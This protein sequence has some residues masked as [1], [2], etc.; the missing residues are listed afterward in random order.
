VRFIRLRDEIVADF[1][2]PGE[3]RHDS[4]S[5][6]DGHDGL[7]SAPVVHPPITEWRLAW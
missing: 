4:N 7:P 3:T 5:S 1:G 2:E 6:H